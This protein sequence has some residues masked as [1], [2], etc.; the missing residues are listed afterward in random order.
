[1][2]LIIKTRFAPSPTGYLHI[3]GLR[4]ALFSYIFAKKNKGQFVL[5]IEDTDQQR[6]VQGATEKL[7]KD[8]SAFGLRADEGVVID[9]N[10]KINQI[11]N[12]GPYI[13]SQRLAKYQQ[14]AK[15]LL[16]S[17][18]AYYCFCSNE[19]LEQ[20]RI[21]QQAQNQ[22]P[23]YDGCCRN[24]NKNEASNR[25]ANG[26]S[27]V[28][29]LAVPKNE[30][31]TVNDEV[32]GRV[33]FASNA[34]DDQVLIKS[35]G[36]PTYHLA[37]VVDDHDMGITHVIRGEEWLPSTPK[38]I[39]LYKMFNWQLPSFAHL[40]LILNKDR[41][42]LSKRQN[43]VAVEDYIKQGY[44]ISAIIN[45]IALLGWHPSKSDKEI[46]TLDELINEF[47]LSKIQKAGAILD[48]D[49]LKWLSAK[50]LSNINNNDIVSWLIKERPKADKI[51]A[52]RLIS[53]CRER[54]TTFSDAVNIYD[55]L[56]V[57]KPKKEQ[58]IFKKSDAVKT[59][60]AIEQVI[61][62]LSN[63]ESVWSEFDLLAKTLK[64]VARFPLSVGDV[65][66]STR[67]ALSGQEKSPPPEELMYILGKDES[68]ERLRSALKLLS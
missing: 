37:V 6:L 45:F 60:L 46:F 55:S 33:V 67:V 1:M 43:D 25:V 17:G 64:E 30:E 10:G 61:E 23:M 48:L 35:D 58:L 11:G 54:L 32:R 47:D 53:T 16:D 2:S 29:R 34:I 15:E 31:V 27:H 9:D 12:S 38:H 51:I 65:F 62:N 44:P 49:K 26:E 63:N 56:F 24:L 22:A 39:L 4:T 66:W 28:I 36:F 18:G 57:F 3:G 40:P 8:L 50:Y 59:K 13:Q 20:M 21:N 14:A 5:R 41:S 52:E 19:R 42:K 7:I 68:L